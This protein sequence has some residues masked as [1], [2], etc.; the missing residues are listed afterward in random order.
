[1]IVR[2]LGRPV[3]V[4]R[5]RRRWLAADQG[6]HHGH[7][8]HRVPRPHH[9]PPPNRPAHPALFPPPPPP[10]QRPPRPAGPAGSGSGG[11]HSWKFTSMRRKTSRTANP[12]P[13]ASPVNE[14]FMLST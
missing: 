6:V 12:S 14:L 1:M 5:L 4:P 11:S 3:L 2:W 7:E 10:P 9:Q 8:E 13:A